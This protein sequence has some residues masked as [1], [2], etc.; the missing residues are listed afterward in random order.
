MIVTRQRK[1]KKSSL[2][3]LLPIAAIVMLGVALAWPPSRNIILNGPLKPFSNIVLSFWGTV[4]RPLTFAYQQQEITDRNIQVKQL[5]DQLEADRK[6]SADKDQQVQSL[7]RAVAAA[8]AQPPEVTPS[9]APVVRPAAAAVAGGA[10]ALSAISPERAALQKTGQQWAAMDPEKAA[11]LI[12]TLPDDYVAQVFAQMSPD[13][14]G[15]IMDN[16]SAK[17]AA[18]IV[19]SSQA[20]ISAPTRR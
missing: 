4:S 5:N 16:L 2:P 18:R 6:T 11:A 17:Q 10:V 9:P 13:D 7:Q 8:N 12:G 15:P 14:V 1:Q 20:Q 19:Q 3:I